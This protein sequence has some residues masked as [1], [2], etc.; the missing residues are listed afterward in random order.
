MHLM[1][2]ICLA[3]STNSSSA[4]KTSVIFKKVV[5]G[6]QRVEAVE[7]ALVK[8]HIFL[9][10]TAVVDIDATFSNLFSTCFFTSI[11]LKYHKKLIE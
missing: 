8:T 4:T 6:N 3:T 2:Q 9:E 10:T 1:Q 7:N 11:V 5:V